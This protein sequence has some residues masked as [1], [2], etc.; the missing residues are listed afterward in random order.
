MPYSKLTWDKLLT[1][2][3]RKTMH[4]GSESI[5]TGVGREEIERDYDR[6]L[7]AAPTRRLADKTQVFPQDPNDSVR[8]RL[9]HSHEVSN[10]GRSIGIRLAYH[11]RKEVFGD[12]ADKARVERTVPA[13]LIDVSLRVP[14]SQSRTSSIWYVMQFQE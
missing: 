1:P 4:G 3:R 13:L 5:G 14:A 2:E 12:Y 8:T 7:F 10:L 11:H 6:I 9:T